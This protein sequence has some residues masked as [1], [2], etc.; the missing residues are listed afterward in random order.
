MDL[1]RK[2][3]QVVGW[4]ES[5]KG[6]KKLLI[7]EEVLAALQGDVLSDDLLQAIEALNE[8]GTESGR[9][10]I[11]NAMKDRRVLPEAIPMDVGERELPLILFLAQKKALLSLKSSLEHRLKFKMAMIVGGITNSWA[12]RPSRS[13]ILRQAVMRCLLEPNSIASSM[14]LVI[15]CRLQPSMMTG[16]TSFMFFAAIT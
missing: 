8:L 4:P 2:L 7:H 1:W 15:T 14:T 16:P 6:K 13:V 9:D 12:R 5:I 11:Q 10:A 3:F